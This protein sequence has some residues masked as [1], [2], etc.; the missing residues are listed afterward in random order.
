MRE[1]DAVTDGGSG[2]A[3]AIDEVLQKFLAVANTRITF[4][5]ADKFIQYFF[6]AIR[7]PTFQLAVFIGRL[8]NCFQFEFDKIFCQAA[9][10]VHIISLS[11]TSST[12]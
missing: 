11:S 3:F 4:K 7:A 2:L 12:G 1:S 6:F 5:N 10:D 8:D 9:R